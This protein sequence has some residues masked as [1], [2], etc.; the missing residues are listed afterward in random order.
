MEMDFPA[1]TETA[2]EARP[3]PLLQKGVDKALEKGD[4][5]RGKCPHPG[6]T[7]DVGI[8]GRGTRETIL[9]AGFGGEIEQDRRDKGM[10]EIEDAEVEGLEAA[11]V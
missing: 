9:T 7:R 3:N 6:G 10:E 8:H 11:C 4:W 1:T 5:N 2:E